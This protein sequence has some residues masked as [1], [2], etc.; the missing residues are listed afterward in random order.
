MNPTDRDEPKGA[1]VTYYSYE[2]K[3]RR[4]PLD[5]RIVIA[6]AT[7]VFGGF[8]RVVVPEMVA[9]LF[10]GYAWLGALFGWLAVGVAVALAIV[11]TRMSESTSSDDF[12]TTK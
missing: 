9:K 3:L 7:L 1:P 11:S 2:A 12:R 8:V 10:P 6:G 5:R 4:N